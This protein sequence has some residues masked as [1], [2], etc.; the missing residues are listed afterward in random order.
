MLARRRWLILLPFAIG[1]AV[2]PVIARFVPKVYRSETLISVIPQRVPDSYVKST[3]TATVEDR[4]PSISDQILSRSRL[5]RIINDFELYPE[6]R[7][8]LPMEDVVRRMRTDVGPISIRRNEQS[9]RV[10]FTSEKPDTAQKVAARLA[11]LFIDENSRDRESLAENTNAFLESQL[12]EAKQ[13]LIEHERKLEVYR[14]AHPGELPSQLD[15][16]LQ[17]IAST[18]LQLQSVSESI[19]RARERRLLVERQLVDAR[20]YP[21]TA[22]QLGVLGASEALPV[23]AAQRLETAQANLRVLKLRYTPDHPDV[24]AVER[25]IIE[26]KEKAEQEANRSPDETPSRAATAEEQVRQKRLRDLQAELDVIDH[27]LSVSEAEEKR[28]REVIASYGRRVEAAPSRESELIEL[29]RDY[30]VLKTSYDTLL[31][32]REDS[33]VAADLERRQI[34]EQFRI[35]DPAPLPAR[36][37]NQMPRAGDLVL[38]GDRGPGS[39]PAADSISRAPQLEFLTG[40]RNRAPAR[41]AGTGPRSDHDSE[42]EQ[43]GRR[44]RT[45]VLD[46]AG[47]G[48]IAASLAVLV[49]WGIRQL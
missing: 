11:S 34:G 6:Q 29:T 2:V 44:L 13:R 30:Q 40:R 15:S 24:R 3:I 22:T 45:L 25:I 16:N 39:R 5:E 41:V 32:K 17:A 43:R 14:K 26:L 7:A 33:K 12:E 20:T 19:N 18:Q 49:V 35:L 31:A 48:V 8:R 36:P 46:V 1:L 28:L 37:S 9:F 21:M 27:Q 4:L 47:T 38:R 10:G 23:S 42:K